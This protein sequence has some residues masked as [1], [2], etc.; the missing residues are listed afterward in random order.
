MNILVQTYG[1]VSGTKGGTERTTIT[2]ASALKRL[3]GARCFSVYEQH[4]EGE[5]EACFEKEFCWQVDRDEQKNVRFLRD[6]IEENHIDAVVVQGAFIHVPRFRRAIQGLNC[7][8]I[9]AH[10]FEPGWELV[11]GRFSERL[12]NRPH[13]A[14][15]TLRWAKSLALQPWTKRQYGRLLAQSYHDA[16]DAAD[17]VVLLSRSFIEPFG[18]F[19]SQTDTRKYAIIPNGLSFPGAPEFDPQ[20]KRPTVLIVARLDESCKRISL[21]LRI[22]KQAKGDKRAEGWQ[23]KIVGQGADHARYERQ[24]RRDNIPDVSLEGRQRPEPYYREASIFMMTSLSE[25]WGLTLTEAQQM[26]AVP[27]AFDSYS[28]L[29]DII[30]HNNDGVIVK[31]GDV[32]GYTEALLRLMTDSELRHRM[33]TTALTTCQR[34]SPDRIAALWWQLLTQR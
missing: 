9:F 20:A 18:R 33:A 12:K 29:R 11:F 10:H 14:L 22:W 25:S 34:F 30:T 17:H 32:E 16:Y 3:Y 7:R 27:I 8:L 1:K 6:I 5:R 4:A 19:A 23:L 26:G 28:S 21:A 13:G 31:E 24:I 2:V 15:N